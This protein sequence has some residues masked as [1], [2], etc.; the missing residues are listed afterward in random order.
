MLKDAQ[1]FIQ[2]EIYYWDFI[3]VQGNKSEI[4]ITD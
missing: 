3:K 4:I 2:W 1:K